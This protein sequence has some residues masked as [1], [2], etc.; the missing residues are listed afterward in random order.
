MVFD[1]DGTLVNSVTVHLISWMEACRVVGIPIKFD[2]HTIDLIKNL[3]GLAAEDIALII[4]GDDESK[5][6]NLVEVKRRIYLE[7]ID[8]IT[9]FP[10]VVDGIKKLRELGLRIAI[11]S[12]TSRKT[13]EAVIK[14]VG[15][16]SYIDAYVGSDEVVRRKPNPEMFLRAMERIGVRASEAVVVG[17]TRYDI[18]PAHELGSVSVLMCWSGC[19]DVDVK[20]TFYAYSMDDVIEITMLLL[21]TENSLK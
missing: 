21:R 4:T 9:P 14:H 8:S 11:A 13:I 12:S 3:V 19:S 1:L 16:H 6:K 5:A 18:A 7:K 10:G 20:P 15:I 17:D 2:I